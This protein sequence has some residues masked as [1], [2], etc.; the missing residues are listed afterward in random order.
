MKNQNGRLITIT[1]FFMAL[2]TF[3]PGVARH[4]EAENKELK[5]GTIAPLTLKEGVEIKR[6]MELFVKITNEKGGWKIGNDTYKLK[7]I[8]YDGGV[9]RDV[10][11]SR[12]AAE[13]LIYQDKVKYMVSNWMEV[14]SQ[15]ATIT[16]P[17]KVLWMGCDFTDVTVK[18]DLK[19]FI[20]ASGVYFARGLSYVI[21]KD[22]MAR[23]AK[24][25]LSVNQ[26][27]QMGQVGNFLWG[28]AAKLAGMEVI[29][30]ITYPPGTV[31]FGPVATKIVSL[32]PD[33]VELSFVTGDQ[34]TNII[35]ALK[36]AGYKGFISPANLNSDILANI[37]AKVGK[38][39]V[40]GMEFNNF[41][42]R[43]VH[44]DLKM[45]SL[46]NRYIKEYGKFQHEG[47]FW[48]GPWFL[49]EDAVLSTKSVDVD[50]LTDY[51]CHSKKGVM[52]LSGYSQLFARPDMGV[53]QTI[54]VAPGHGIGIVKNGKITLLKKVSVKDQYLVS[55]AVYGK[56]DVYKKY[57]DE[58][59]YPTFPNEPSFIDFSNVLN[60]KKKK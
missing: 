14:P 9:G 39:Y 11:K 28:E 16:E 22:F 51:L 40:E 13:R 53:N 23:G 47:V 19:Y 56:V 12:V 46:I 49:F 2:M 30:G 6:W 36:D 3:L 48:A 15:T 21:H 42:P 54:D 17:N 60:L 37:I 50:V 59:G 27:N 41:D 5:I 26:D 31:D 52:T 8:V 1:L 43:G 35:A 33:L 55:V 20:R 4:V 45:Q 38:Q 25:E 29:P 32:Q 24:R 57:W 58:Y 34:I 7:S 18:P 44:N 10:A